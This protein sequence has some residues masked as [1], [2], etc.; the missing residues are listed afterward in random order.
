MQKGKYYKIGYVY[1]TLSDG[2]SPNEKKHISL[3][4]I[5]NKRQDQMYQVRPIFNEIK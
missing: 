2:V 1:N 5:F 4:N 3:L